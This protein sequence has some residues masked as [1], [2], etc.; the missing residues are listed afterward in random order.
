MSYGPNLADAYRNA[1]SYVALILKGEK[2]AELPV[3]QPT[4]FEFI[5]NLKVAKALAL[6]IPANVL[7]LADDV[8]E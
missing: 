4:T 2:P 7:A 3:L 5:I 1:A 6:E 8:I